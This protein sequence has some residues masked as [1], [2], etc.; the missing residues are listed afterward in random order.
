MTNKEESA[1]TFSRREFIKGALKI[2]GAAALGESVTG[3]G[4]PSVEASYPGEPTEVTQNKPTSI[5]ESTPESTPTTKPTQTPEVVET[6]AV[7]KEITPEKES[8]YDIV[9]SMYLDTKTATAS[10]FSTGGD[11]LFGSDLSQFISEDRRQMLEGEPLPIEKL[12]SI[13][14]GEEV[15]FN[16]LGTDPRQALMALAAFADF[17][18]LEGVGNIKTMSNEYASEELKEKLANEGIFSNE[19]NIPWFERFHTNTKEIVIEKGASEGEVIL[20]G[21]NMFV[22]GVSEEGDQ[23]LVVVSN[24]LDTNEEQDKLGVAALKMLA[25]PTENFEELINSVEGASYDSG[26]I[27]YEKGEEKLLIEPN[28]VGKDTYNSIIKNTSEV[29]EQ[30]TQTPEQENRV[31][32]ASEFSHLKDSEGGEYEFGHIITTFTHELM[33]GFGMFGVV[34]REP[35]KENIEIKNT[36]GE[37]I[38]SYQGWFVDIGYL[39]QEYSDGRLTSSKALVWIDDIESFSYVVGATTTVDQQYIMRGGNKSNKVTERDEYFDYFNFG[40][41]GYFDFHVREEPLSSE[42]IGGQ[43]PGE[44]STQKRLYC[45]SLIFGGLSEIGSTN[46]SNPPR[47]EDIKKWQEEGAGL[48]EGHPATMRKYDYLGYLLF[49][50]I[51]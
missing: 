44:N 13:S 19:A 16:K 25:I 40:D 10:F 3:C 26:K 20:P 31:Y 15:D 7:A 32:Y 21:T 1:N 9:P 17:Q 14:F 48:V 45:L 22:I 12:A 42:K 38:Q 2:T 37:V 4:T 18:G 36:N 34:L 35:Y 50:Y 47:I 6:Q 46:L 49:S 5:P 8:D 39:D 23:A 29:E 51:H 11:N 30:P 33:D 24:S 28:I 41:P 43:F 27:R